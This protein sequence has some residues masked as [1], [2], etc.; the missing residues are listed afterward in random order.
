MRLDKFICGATTL[1]RRQAKKIIAQGRIN[2][3][4]SVMR[5]TDYK[6]KETQ[7]ITFDDKI[8]TMRG[9]R[10]ILL[11][12]PR[13]YICSNIDEQLPSIFNLI[14]IEKKRAIIYSRSIRCRHHRSDLDY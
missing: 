5:Q 6:I 10:Y 4:S 12:K 1:T 3:D 2:C 8:L 9:S 11:N 7:V 14:D 13:G